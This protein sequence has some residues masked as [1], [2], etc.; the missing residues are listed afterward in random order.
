MVPQDYEML[1]KETQ[2]V[3]SAVNWYISRM[4]DNDVEDSKGSYHPT[5]FSGQDKF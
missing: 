5:H 4:N 2:N 1:L 3:R